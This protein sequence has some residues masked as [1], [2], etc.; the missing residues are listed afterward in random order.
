[1]K[2]WY[3]LYTRPRHEKKAFEILTDKNETVFLPLLKTVKLVR[4][5]KRA[6]ELPLFP[7][8]LFCHFNF[9]DRYDILQTHGIIKIVSFKSVPAVVPDW[10]IE[11][12][13]KI[14]ENP[15][16]I[17][18]EN[19]YRQGD[20]V[21]VKAGPFIGLRGSITT[22]KGVSRLVITIEGIM[23]SLSVELDTDSVEQV[24]KT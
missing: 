11:S 7:S 12:L 3:A 16:T 14:L 1:M 17:R 22:I 18:M 13:K 15:Q 24:S 2:K 8:Y 10:Q 6:V 19:Y 9:K 4:N 23:Q 20:L 5:R 21:E